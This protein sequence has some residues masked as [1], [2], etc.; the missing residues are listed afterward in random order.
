MSLSSL[1]HKLTYHVRNWLHGSGFAWNT[2]HMSAFLVALCACIPAG[3]ISQI[4]LYSEPWREHLGYSVVEVN[5][6]FS[7][8][9]LGGYITPPLLGLLSDAHGP[10]MLSWLS[11]VGFVPTYAY[12]A[13]V[14]ASGEPHFYASV[15][16]FTLIGISTN[17]LYFSALFTA[18]KLYPASKL[19]S[20]SLPATFY[21]MASVLGS[22]LLK[23][24]WFRNGLPYLDLSRVFRTLAVAYTLISF[25]MWFATS[26]VTMLKVKAATLTF[27]G[28]QSP[29]EP[30]LPQD[31]RRRLRNFFHDPAAYFMALVLL[32]SLGPMEM[33]L[34]NMGSLS[35]LLGQASVLPEF[36]IA[37]TC[38]RFLSGLIIDLC[39]HNGVSTMSVQWAVLLLGVVGQ[40]IVVLATRASDGPLLSLASALSGACYGGLFT[41]SPILTLAVWG[42]A[43]FGTAY[44]SFMIT[45]AV[46]S[47]LFGLTYAHIFDANCTPS[48]VLPVCIQHV[49]WSSTSAL[50]IALLFSVLMYLVFW[51]RKV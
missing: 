4:S 38:S 19:C 28:M 23:I 11:F 37:S 22:Q 40:W 16:C 26:I 10:V 8:V 25:C 27:A 2:L 17:A 21:G 50:A 41:V 31:I 3:F 36:A 12:A 35:S 1:E 32:L 44:G 43:V 15:L 5:V 9:N 49:F 29:T 39:I 45:P 6:L 42:D 47:I 48:G 30:L 24:P 33:F 13:W 20:I 7:A 51:R 14:F 18:S 46:G 34:T